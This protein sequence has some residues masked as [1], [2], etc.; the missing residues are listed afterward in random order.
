MV[1]GNAL[2]AA[3]RDRFLFEATTATSRFARTVADTTQNSW[4]YV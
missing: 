4:K 2:Q 3:N 1:G